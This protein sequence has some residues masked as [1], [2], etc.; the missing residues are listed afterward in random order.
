MNL[1]WLVPVVNVIVSFREFLFA[2][3][4][5]RELLY[6]YRVI[7][8]ESRRVYTSSSYSL[9]SHSAEG[10]ETVARVIR[11]C[12]I[13]PPYSE[14]YDSPASALSLQFHI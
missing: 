1:Q 11:L 12:Y 4:V 14:R 8:A 13:N 2:V 5:T 6:R 10:D 9:T 7:G 3:C